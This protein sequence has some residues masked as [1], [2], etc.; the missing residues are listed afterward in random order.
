[1]GV[2]REAIKEERLPE[3]LEDLLPLALWALQMGLLV[4]FLYDGSEGQMR[5]RRLADG[6]LELTMSLLKLAWL[7]L[8]KPVRVKVLGLLR[9]ADLLPELGGIEEERWMR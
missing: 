8:M 7:P 5:T 2:F 9:E 6:A 3:D 4:M 1:M